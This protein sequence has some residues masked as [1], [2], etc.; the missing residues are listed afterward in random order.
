MPKA[1]QNER[2]A[3]CLLALLNVTKATAWAEAEAPLMGITP[4][5]EFARKYYQRDYAPNTRET[6]RRR[7]AHQLCQAGLVLYNP[8]DPA[9]PTNSPKAAYQ[10]EPTT[11][12]L[13]RTFGTPEWPRKLTAYLAQHK[14]LAERN[15]KARKT[16]LIPVTLAN[17]DAIRLSPGEHN[18]LIKA[19]I[20]EFA[21]RFLPGAMLVYAGDTGDKWGYFDG[22]R[23]RDLGVSVDEH[24]KMPDVVFHC[25]AKSW[26]VLVES[27]TSHGPVDSKRHEDLRHLFRSASPGLVFV[28]AFPDRSTMARYLADIAW[29]TDV[30]VAE[31]PTHMVHFNGSRFLGPY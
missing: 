6:F 14:T 12:A 15:A 23:L 9:R 26:L 25:P 28:T 16:A 21:P 22:A 20:E 7:S 3:L 2:T 11:L 10:V 8:D 29:E 13:L 19:V 27:V 4:M 30:W 24:G 17:G 1:Q 18:Q 31:D 5:L